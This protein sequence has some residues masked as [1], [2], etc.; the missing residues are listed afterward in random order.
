[1]RAGKAGRTEV[2]DAAIR[3]AAPLVQAVLQLAYLLGEGGQ[4]LGSGCRLCLRVC[5]GGLVSKADLAG[6]VR[7]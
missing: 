2:V 7:R 1:M 6:G 3:R 4:V 5:S